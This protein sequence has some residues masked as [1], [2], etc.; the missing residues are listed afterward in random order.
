MIVVYVD[1]LDAEKTFGLV[2]DSGKIERLIDQIQGFYTKINSIKPIEKQTL[3]VTTELDRYVIVYQKD[4]RYNSTIIYV[5]DC[6]YDFST[7]FVVREF[8]PFSDKQTN[9]IKQIQDEIRQNIE[10]TQ[11]V[12]T[13]ADPDELPTDLEGIYS[14]NVERVVIQKAN[15]L[16]VLYELDNAEHEESRKTVIADEC[17]INKFNIRIV[18][19]YCFI[20]WEQQTDKK[21]NGYRYIK[22]RDLTN[23][24]DKI[25]HFEESLKPYIGDKERAILKEKIDTFQ[26]RSG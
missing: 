25:A 3:S 12:L 7:S 11:V 4:F 26:L 24:F 21:D 15:E 14:C 20:H 16:E 10:E 8:K 18:N 5:I 17:I 23:N 19:L 1:T 2:V 22:L 13:D 6:D 9:Q